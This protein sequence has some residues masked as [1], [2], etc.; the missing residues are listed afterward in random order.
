MAKRKWL[1]IGSVFLVLLLLAAGAGWLYLWIQ[2]GVVRQ[3][4]IAHLQDQ[5][6][7]V[8]VEA[9]TVWWL[10]WDSIHV[11][12]LSSTAKPSSTLAWGWGRLPSN[13]L[14]R[15]TLS[16]PLPC[17]PMPTMR[18]VFAPP[19]SKNGLL[20]GLSQ[21]GNFYCLNA[22]SGKTVWAETDAKRGNFG[23]ILDAGS[24]RSALTAKSHLI[25]FQPSDTAYSEVASIKVADTE[26]YA[27]PVLAG[28]RV[29][30]EDQDSVTLW[31]LD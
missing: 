18:R 19:C 7:D 17:G 31:T 4:L 28:N 20:F 29:F 24:V 15:A 11:N 21:A 1:F 30:V 14:N 10:P 25:V 8:D 3:K 13:S 22:Q 6:N 27:H 5:F 12:E 16:P 26:T 9:G 2:S 23:S